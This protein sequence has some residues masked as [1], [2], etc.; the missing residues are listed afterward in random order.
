MS[1]VLCVLRE[2]VT[3]SM[4][5]NKEHFF[6]EKLAME[7]T[8]LKKGVFITRVRSIWLA[9]QGEWLSSWLVMK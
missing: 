8:L 6:K 2:N 4:Y 7:N 3:F 1:V 5:T 9:C